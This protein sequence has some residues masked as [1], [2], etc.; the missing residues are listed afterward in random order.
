MS[1]Y[2]LPFYRSFFF[3][4]SLFL[5]LLGIVPMGVVTYLNFNY[6]SRILNDTTAAGLYAIAQYQ[7]KNIQGFMGGVQKD[8]HLLAETPTFVE[9]LENIFQV[10]KKPYSKQEL[11]E[12]EQQLNT[13]SLDIFKRFIDELNFKNI[14]LASPD[15][16][17]LYNIAEKGFVEESDNKTSTDTPAGSHKRQLLI[18][19]LELTYMVMS[20]QVSDFALNAKEEDPC[21]LFTCPVFSKGVLIGLLAVEVSSQSIYNILN[22]YTGLDETG[23]TVIS[24]QKNDRVILLNPT[25]N[26][27]H[28]VFEEDTFA[29]QESSA[30]YKALRGERGFGPGVDYRGKSVLAAWEYLPRLRWGLVVKKDLSEVLNPSV[31]LQNIAFSIVLPSTCVL[32]LIAIFCAQRI[33]AP[34]SNLAQNAL[35]LA[36]GNLDAVY[37]FSRSNNELKLLSKALCS[38]QEHLKS[39]VSKTKSTEMFVSDVHSKSLQSSYMQTKAMHTHK[40][41]LQRISRVSKHM[42]GLN[43][44]LIHTI[45]D[46]TQTS[47]KAVS[48]AEASQHKLKTLIAI[49]QS[50]ES[51]KTGLEE[52]FESI[53]AQVKAIQGIFFNT[54]KM[55]D[56]SNILALN[57]TLEVHQ[58][59]HSTLGF[60]VVAQEI[61][62]LSQEMDEACLGLEKNTQEM[63][64]SINR[65]SNYLKQFSKMVHEESLAAGLMHNYLDQVMGHITHLPAPLKEA[66]NSLEQQLESIQHIDSSIQA[67]QQTTEH[68]AHYLEDSKQSIHRLRA[69]SLKLEKEVAEFRI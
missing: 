37:V 54:L 42:E 11:K 19:T 45:K 62:K 10:S 60:R 16:Q 67:L 28:L 1:A 34:L 36:A 3:Q 69:H 32:L 56:R 17:A 22:N 14:F 48:E 21:L 8:I 13:H 49:I 20:P 46:L 40:T 33:S 41:F 4:L 15:C 2:R 30:M 24:Q 25:R 61:Q 68:K 65:A 23:E 26:A 9:A 39:L 29:K 59:A 35:K 58:M 43:K 38:M 6:G 50:V 31:R 66:L 53:H 63:E 55:A 51:A 47:H 18:K 52:H 7:S 12:L 27:A 5:S 57:T 44:D 64:Q